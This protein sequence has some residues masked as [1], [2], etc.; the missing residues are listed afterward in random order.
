MRDVGNT[1]FVISHTHTD[2]MQVIHS[3]NDQIVPIDATGRASAR[4]VANAKLI[5][6][7]GAPHG[8]TD[9][10]KDKLNVVLLAF[11]RD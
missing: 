10:Q 3:D 2:I 6:Y 1:M 7:P 11:L 4:I 9:A 8:I 5:V